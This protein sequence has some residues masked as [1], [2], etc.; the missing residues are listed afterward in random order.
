MEKRDPQEAKLAGAIAVALDTKFPG[1]G[2]RNRAAEA[3]GIEPSSLSRYLASRLPPIRKLSPLL[4]KVGVKL[5]D[6]ITSTAP[7]THS[8]PAPSPRPIPLLGDLGAGRPRHDPAEA[9]D[10][11]QVNGLF[12]DTAVA[13]RVKGRSMEVD[14]ILDGD[15]VVAVPSPTADG[16]AKVVAW[17][18]G[19]GGYLKRYDAKKNTIYSGNGRNRWTHVM[20]P[21]D[22]I[23]GVFVG[24]IRKG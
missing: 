19:Q 18:D 4:E 13:Y 16:G 1:R 21:E 3:M 20:R 17:V 8:R 2:G 6:L 7:P 11:L 5:A 9:T 10:S 23:V 24:L 12:P 15:F 14:H 22:L